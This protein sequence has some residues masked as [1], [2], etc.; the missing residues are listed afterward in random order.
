MKD[1][2][3][4]IVGVQDFGD[5]TV[6]NARHRLSGRM[7]NLNTEEL[8][9]EEFVTD[10][11]R[12]TV[13]VIHVPNHWPRRPVYAH[14]KAWQ[15]LDDNLVPMLQERLDAILSEPLEGADWSAV[16]ID[17]ASIFDL[18]ELAIA[19]ARGKYKEKHKTQP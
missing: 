2:T 7:A 8:R 16:V 10:D 17:K 18:D 1:K 4:D 15:R 19:T 14:G 3:L 12:K 11:T 5:F 9:V 13:W 6:D